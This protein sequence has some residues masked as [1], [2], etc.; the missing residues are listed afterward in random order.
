MADIFNSYKNSIGRVFGIAK[1]SQKTLLG[2]CF[3]IAP[4]FVLTCHHVVH[5]KE[6]APRESIE[7]VFEGSLQNSIEATIYE[8]GGAGID[9]TVLKLSKEV[10]HKPF[11]V[12][13]GNLYGEDF[14]TFGYPFGHGGGGVTESGKILGPTSTSAGYRRLELRSEK[15]RIKEGFS[16]APVFIANSDNIGCVIGC[17]SETGSHTHSDVPSCTPIYSLIERNPDLNN[18]F[19]SILNY[20]GNKQ[21][22][23]NLIFDGSES[24]TWKLTNHI[25]NPNQISPE[26]LGNNYDVDKIALEVFD[27]LNKIK[28]KA[29]DS[30]EQLVKELRAIITGLRVKYQGLRL[31]LRSASKL[32]NEYRKIYRFGKEPSDDFLY[33]KPDDRILQLLNEAELVAN[34]FKRIRLDLLNLVKAYGAQIHLNLLNNVCYA[35]VSYLRS[36]MDHNIFLQDGYAWENVARLFDSAIEFIEFDLTKLSRGYLNTGYIKKFDFSSSKTLITLTHESAGENGEPS[37]L[38]YLED[39]KG[40]IEQTARLVARKSKFTDPILVKS[41][42]EVKVHAISK[43]YLYQWQLN[44]PT[45]VFEFD[46]GM[47]FQNNILNYFCFQDKNDKDELMIHSP[48]RIYHLMGGK[49]I[50]EW[51]KKLDSNNIVVWKNEETQQLQLTYL[52]NS[53]PRL[54]ITNT[55]DSNNEIEIELNNVLDKLYSD[56]LFW[57]CDKNEKK[58]LFRGFE[59]LIT[60]K[61]VKL[62]SSSF[63]EISLGELKGSRCFTILLDL[64]P[65]GQAIIFLDPYSL[66]PLRT[67]IISK[68]FICNYKIVN[69]NQSTILIAT[70]LNN[71]QTKHN[72]AA[73]DITKVSSRELPPALGVWHE[74]LEDATYIEVVQYK[75]NWEAYYIVEPFN[76]LENNQWS[77]WKFNWLDKTSQHLLTFPPGRI[78]GL[79]VLAMKK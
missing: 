38:I 68:Q 27:A 6:N 24:S 19:S 1:N 76:L 29:K 78:S 47:A 74:S 59:D 43:Q 62:E 17:I 11:P 15:D 32:A 70:L 31:D 12:F 64:Y 71:P 58:S 26:L 20:P 25:L 60:E 75:D 56:I 2:T 30:D 23:K 51:F 73:W 5:N 77:L 41:S 50:N 35:R 72:L 48:P 53:L 37:L 52:K 49:L 16:G 42:R 28:K 39:G 3:L 46:A 54:I 66:Q 33:A 45:P 36:H 57:D 67:P 9:I 22:N 8:T 4:R 18:I 14:D 40:L 13:L 79:S 61:G 21:P 44:S 34:D 10:P 63:Q 7:I 69:F 55:L 65:I